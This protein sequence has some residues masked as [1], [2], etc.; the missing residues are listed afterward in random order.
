MDEFAFDVADASSNGRRLLSLGPGTLVLIVLINVLVALV[1]IS[2][3]VCVVLH[4]TLNRQSVRAFTP[5]RGPAQPIEAASQASK[6]QE[7]S[8]AAPSQ[9]QWFEVS[10]L[11]NTT[12][13]CKE[14]QVPPGASGA[15][16]FPALG[17]VPEAM[18]AVSIENCEICCERNA[19][20][21]LLPC[22]HGGM[23]RQCSEEILRRSA[24]HCPHCRGAVERLVLVDSPL[25]LLQGEVCLGTRIPMLLSAPVNSSP[26][27]GH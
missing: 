20:M 23:C 7:K 9:E 18:A 26:N 24:G 16:N 27:A 21:V 17:A 2:A 13:A 1:M 6:V 8:P 12:F 11:S 15:P 4:W 10:R 25:R 3:V 14:L 5:S 22:S 19:E